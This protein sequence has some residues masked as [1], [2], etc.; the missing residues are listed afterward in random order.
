MDTRKLEELQHKMLQEIPGA[1]ACGVISLDDGLPVAGATADPSM[2]L[3]IPAGMFTQ[4]FQAAEKAFHYSGWGDINELILSG[5]DYL[6][7]LIRVGGQFYEGI[8]TRTGVQLGLVRAVFKR[9]VRE[10][11][12]ALQA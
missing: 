3:E 9:F 7:I 5:P 2:D 8:A 11:D 1:V 6:V 10:I 4:A 12:A